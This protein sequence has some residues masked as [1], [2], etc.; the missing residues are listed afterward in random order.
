MKLY[1]AR[2]GESEGNV[3]LL[4][5]GHTDCPLTEN[6]RADARAL[7]AKLRELEL[8]RCYSSP[9]SRAADTACL[10]LEGT[11]VP[12]T[13]CDDLKEQY[14]GEL[15]NIPFAKV[16]EENPELVRAMIVNW[17]DFVPP[18][19]ESFE[20]VS[21]RTWRCVQEIISR[22]ED[23]L[24]VAHNGSLSA[25]FTRLLDVP[26]AAIDKF[27]FEHGSFS[28]VDITDGRVRLLY[29]NK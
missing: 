15:E 28:C 1:F 25:I 12:I 10:A 9:L 5:Y 8:A 4:L 21:E 17:S 7:G 24:I 20:Q 6:G 11:D 26:A 29:F 2:H 19:G 27:W 16:R 3:K 14:L 18:G 23:A 13:F 22:G